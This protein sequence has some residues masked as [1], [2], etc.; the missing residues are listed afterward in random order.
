MEIDKYDALRSLVCFKLLKSMMKAIGLE[1]FAALGGGVNFTDECG[2]EVYIVYSK[3]SGL[4]WTTYMK[5]GCSRLIEILQSVD[6]FHTPLDGEI[7]N[8]YKDCSTVEEMLVT[9]DLVCKSHSQ[10]QRP[11]SID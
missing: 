7:D 9:R 10:L 8:P 4:M 11:S 6:G 1:L 3:G 2:N 5:D